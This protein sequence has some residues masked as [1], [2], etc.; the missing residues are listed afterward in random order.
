MSADATPAGT[1]TYYTVFAILLV[2]TYLTWQ[3]AYFDFGRLNT[4][5]ALSIA[6]V[7]ATLVVLFFMHARNGPRLI[8]AIAFGGLFWLFI[9]LALTAGDYLTR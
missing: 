4:V 5:V 1:R 6:G 9:L 3:I 2:C 7:K 8:W